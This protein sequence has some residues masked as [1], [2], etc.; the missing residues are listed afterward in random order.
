[1]HRWQTE[2][3]AELEGHWPPLELTVYLRLSWLL[4]FWMPDLCLLCTPE[5]DFVFHRYSLNIK[6]YLWNSDWQ[7]LSLYSFMPLFKTQEIWWGL[8]HSSSLIWFWEEIQRIRL[9]SFFFSS[10]WVRVSF[11][12]VERE[13]KEK[14]T[15][16]RQRD[17]P[18]I[19]LLGRWDGVW[20]CLWDCVCYISLV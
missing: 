20:F 12:S 4:L 8:F 18:G 7:S 16:K 9:V 10:F 11:S 17:N 5:P 14:D 6:T 2:A 3:G 19:M 15:K 1:M 13:Q